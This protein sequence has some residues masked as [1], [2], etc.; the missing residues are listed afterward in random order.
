MLRGCKRS[1]TPSSFAK[2]QIDGHDA[3]SALRRICAANIAVPVA[4]LL[5]RNSS[6]TVAGSKR[7]VTITR[8][9]EDEYFIVTGTGYATRD[10]TTSSITCSA[11]VPAIRRPV[12]LIDVTSASALSSWAPGRR[13]SWPKRRGDL[14]EYHFPQHRTLR[15]HRWLRRF[16]RFA[17]HSSG[18]GWELFVPTEYL[19]RS[20]AIKDAGES[21]GL[22][23][24]YRAI[25]CFVLKKARRYGAG[26]GPDYTPLEAG[27]ASPSFHKAV[28]SAR[29]SAQWRRGR[30]AAAAS[31]RRRP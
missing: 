24:G 6:M 29:A 23:R 18:P 9:R 25:D 21:F 4:P 15:V 7:T 13:I 16:M 3:G 22:R 27:S 31:S 5:I 20:I 11:K 26:F 8:L 2:I 30:S 17:C 10:A 1:S 14:D 12:K 19:V 28:S